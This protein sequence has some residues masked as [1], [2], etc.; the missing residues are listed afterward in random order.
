M[1]VGTAPT[2]S[3]SRYIQL[4]CNHLFEVKELDQLLDEQFEESTV[5]PLTCPYCRKQIRFSHRYG[6]MIKKK[7]EMLRKLRDTMT[8]PVSA[9]QQAVTIKKVSK[10]VPSHMRTEY[11]VVP[12][13]LLASMLKRVTQFLPPTFKKVSSLFTPH[14]HKYE[15]SI[16]ENEA[17]LYA[18]LK[19]MHKQYLESSETS[20]S[21]QELIVFFEKAPASAQKS[22]DV[23]SEA[24]RIF[25]LQMVSSLRPAIPQT[26]EDY[27]LVKELTKKLRVDQ[28]RLL[29]VSALTNHFDRLQKMAEKLKI[30]INRVDLKCL[31][32]TKATN[33]TNGVWIICSNGHL[34]CRPRGLSGK[35][36]WQCPDCITL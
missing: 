23:L 29:S 10:F 25:T 14:Q 34:F 13:T 30:R 33:F 11:E 8:E 2:S 7:K 35:E 15:N 20:T 16:I 17:D 18:Y 21:L 27:A 31:Q 9:E 12:D 32:P 22:H 36:A 28:P 26:G 19:D 3:D 1:Y 5:E 6:N 4:S 24:L